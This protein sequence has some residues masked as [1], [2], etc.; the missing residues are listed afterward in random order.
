M[1]DGE[2]KA[3]IAPQRGGI[4]RSFFTRG[5][6][7]LYL[8]EATLHDP[9]AN[10]RGGVPILFPTP[11][12]LEGDT[13]ARAGK[14]GSL[15]QHG[16]ARNLPWTVVSRT[17]SSARL[18][19][20]SSDAT[21]V[22]YPWEFGFEI[23]FSVTAS[24][25][26]LDL[27]IENRGDAPMPFGVGFHPY[28][29]LADADKAAASIATTAS[30]AFD[31]TVKRDVDLPRIALAAKEV[32]LHLHGHE[33]GALELVDGP[34][35]LAVKASPEMSQWVVWTLAGKDFVCLEPWTG[36]GNAMNTG[37]GLVTLAPSTSARMWMAIECVA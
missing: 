12:K 11:G 26:R 4:V 3:A 14:T 18:R 25:L 31:N 37:K 36:P 23:T 28:F 9:K 34:R 27:A 30:R 29:R 19:I 32:D 2:T 22:A 1:S 7:L 16:F 20:E 35:R 10:V 15:K 24:M 5:R 33:G 8:D 6:E 13:W 17:E 21:R